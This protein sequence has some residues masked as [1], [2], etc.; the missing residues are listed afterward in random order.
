VS[1]E[2]DNIANTPGNSQVL[3]TPFDTIMI[4]PETGRTLPAAAAAK[5]GEAEAGGADKVISRVGHLTRTLHD[6]LRELGYNKRLEEA[7]STIPD[8][9]DRLA[10]VSV[11]TEQAAERSLNATDIAKPIQDKLAADAANL[12]GL[13]KQALDTQSSG[14]LG[15]EALKTLITQTTNYLDDVPNQTNATNAQLLDI[16]M[17]Q[18]FQ[19]LTGQVMKK[20]TQMVQFLEYELMRLLLDNIPADKRGEASA[21]LM[22]GP[23]VNPEGRSDVVTNQ[24]Q[25]DDLLASLGF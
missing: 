12:S 24:N 5:T 9:R 1:Q 4:H 3:D 25:V 20:I 13:W 15:A 10:Y 6:S 18:D 16:M 22:N 11:M 23:V 8:A 14:A 7:A 17:A 19:D 2:V 21:G